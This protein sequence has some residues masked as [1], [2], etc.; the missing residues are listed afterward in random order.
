MFLNIDGLSPSNTHYKSKSLY[1]ALVD[2]Q[3]DGLGLQELNTYWSNVPE[4]H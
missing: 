3:V 4:E 2:I 1:V